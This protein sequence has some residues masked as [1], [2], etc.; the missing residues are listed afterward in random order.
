V[1]RAAIVFVLHKPIAIQ[2]RLAIGLCK[3]LPMLIGYARV[4]R[5]DGL[6]LT[7]DKKWSLRLKDL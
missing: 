5:Q 1:N 2:T 4:S 3:I 7:K 6:V